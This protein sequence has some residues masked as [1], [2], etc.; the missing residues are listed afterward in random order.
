MFSPSV[1]KV[2]IQ[3]DMAMAV[4]IYTPILRDDAQNFNGVLVFADQFFR[5][6]VL[7]LKLSWMLLFEFVQF[8][9]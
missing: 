5:C 8:N 9:N 6:K 4:Y 7:D 2:L 1:S 3:P